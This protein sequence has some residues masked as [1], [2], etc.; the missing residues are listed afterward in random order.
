VAV[1]GL[2]REVASGDE[3]R[4]RVAVEDVHA[5]YELLEAVFK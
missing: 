3:K 5:K 2:Q 4:V 1:T